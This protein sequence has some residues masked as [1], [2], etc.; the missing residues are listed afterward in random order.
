[1]FQDYR[2]LGVDVRTFRLQP[3]KPRLLARGR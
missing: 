3:W 2:R 1:M